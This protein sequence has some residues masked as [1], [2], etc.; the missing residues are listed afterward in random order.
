MSQGKFL[1]SVIAAA[2]IL[3]G[4][5]LLESL[6]QY[7]QGVS[8]WIESQYDFSETQQGL[9][10]LTCGILLFIVV[11]LQRYFEGKLGQHTRLARNITGLPFFLYLA[12]YVPYSLD[13]QDAIA[14]IIFGT[15]YLITLLVWWWDD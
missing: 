5:A 8:L 14:M 11:Y 15:V 10:L 1:S 2:M 3:I 7:N 6:S 13:R 4:I 12:A 9:V